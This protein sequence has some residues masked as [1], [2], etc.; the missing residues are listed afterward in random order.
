MHSYSWKYNI[1]CCQFCGCVLGSLHIKK[2]GGFCTK[3]SLI[4]TSLL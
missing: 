4:Y 2:L 3:F 1:T